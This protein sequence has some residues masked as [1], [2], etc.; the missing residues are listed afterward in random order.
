[1]SHTVDQNC[2]LREN[3]FFLSTS[4][5][6]LGQGELTH[7]KVLESKKRFLEIR[8]EAV[9]GRVCGWQSIKENVTKGGFQKALRKVSR[10]I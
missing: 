6:S 10:M 9:R 1:M 5:R 7:R 4:S 2:A 8:L 3:L